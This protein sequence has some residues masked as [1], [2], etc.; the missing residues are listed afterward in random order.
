MLSIKEV[1]VIPPSSVII[2]TP[3]RDIPFV[4]NLP[5]LSSPYC[6]GDPSFTASSRFNN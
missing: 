1:L 3:S 5:I 6:I 4:V 2:S